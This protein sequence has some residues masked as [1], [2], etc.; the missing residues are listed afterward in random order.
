MSLQFGLLGKST[1][2]YAYPV[3]EDEFTVT[4]K[5]QTIELQF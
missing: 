5:L 1:Q 4:I 2:Y 3:K